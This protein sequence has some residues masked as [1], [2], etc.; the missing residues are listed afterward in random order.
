MKTAMAITICLCNLVFSIRRSRS[1]EVVSYGSGMF[2]SKL[3]YVS[4]QAKVGKSQ[5]W[6]SEDGRG[7]KKKVEGKGGRG[8]AGAE[9]VLLFRMRRMQPHVRIVLNAQFTLNRNKM[10]S[11]RTDGK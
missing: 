10:V 3:A 7:R 2:S 9:M 6:E 4:Y 11:V 5:L 8:G 1:I